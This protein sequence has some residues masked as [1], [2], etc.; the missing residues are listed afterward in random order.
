ME[1]YMRDEVSLPKYDTVR[2]KCVNRNELCCFWAAVGECENNPGFMKLSCAPACKTCNLIDFE[3]RCPRDPNAKDIF[4]PGDLNK[5]FNSILE[6]YEGATDLSRPQIAND[7]GSKDADGP[8]IVTIEDF[9]SESEC[10]RLIELGA[11]KG[12]KRSEDVGEENFDGSFGSTQSSSRTSWNA[13]CEKECLEDPTTI[14]VSEKIVNLT[15]IPDENSE[16]LQLLRYYE[17]QFYRTHH[18]FIDHQI[19]RPTGPRILTIYLY[20]NDVEEGG[21]TRFP[22]LDLTV[23][24]KRGMALIWPSVY[25]SDLIKLDPRTHHEA[26]PVGK[27]IKY[28]ANGWIHLREFKKNH[29]INCS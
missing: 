20:L 13:W 27:G 15:G 6:N 14:N 28:G 12:Y 8:W 9:L 11:Q 19:H 2:D 26:L 23:M 21:G 29:E 4:G 22:R 16:H 25:D 24:P 5:M 3:T 10:E 1:K 18:D 7:E 17:G